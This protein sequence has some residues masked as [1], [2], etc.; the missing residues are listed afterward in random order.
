MPR[1]FVLLFCLSSI[2]LCFLLNVDTAEST[3]VAHRFMS[4]LNSPRLP[5]LTL[6]RTGGS[7][8]SPENVPSF[9]LCLALLLCFQTARNPPAA[10]KKDREYV[11][12]V[13][14]II[15]RSKYFLLGV[16]V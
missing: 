5:S 13:L 16:P 15:S 7:C 14:D 10:P 12:N 1:C 2:S 6:S 8:L 9:S 4:I 3:A 11:L